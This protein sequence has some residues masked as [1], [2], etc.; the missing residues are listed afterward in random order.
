MKIMIKKFCDA[1]GREIESN[2]CEF[3]Y[4]CHIENDGNW[5]NCY[6]DNEWNRV[7]VKEIFKDVCAGCYN[8]IVKKSYDEFIRIRSENK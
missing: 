3:K 2:C 1:C 4:K 8:K 7:S 6:S 5:D